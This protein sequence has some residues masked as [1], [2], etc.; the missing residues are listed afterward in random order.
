MNIDW[1]SILLFGIHQLRVY[2]NPALYNILV[3]VMN[4]SNDENKYDIWGWL[5]LY[6]CRGPFD[7]F[8]MMISKYFESNVSFYLY[9]WQPAESTICR[10]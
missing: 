5:N 9:P 1:L 4:E 7:L 6:N 3:V 8:R 10:I 2:V